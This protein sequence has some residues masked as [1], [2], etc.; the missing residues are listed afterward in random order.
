MKYVDKYN[1]SLP[2]AVFLCHDTYDHNPNP[3]AISATT[4]NKPMREVV[5]ARQNCDMEKVV[6]ISQLISSRM[7]TA[8]H[9]GAEAAWRNPAAIKNALEAKGM[10]RIADR[11]II[12]PSHLELSLDSNLL[13]VYLEQRVSKEVEGY[14]VTGKFDIVY[15][16][17]LSDYKSTTVWSYVFGSNVQD[18]IRQG[19]IYRYLAPDKITS[20]VIEI[21]Y[22]FTDWSKQRAMQDKEY[23]QAKYLT[24]QFPLWSLDKTEM[25]L[26]GRLQMLKNLLPKEQSVLPMC[27]KEELWQGDTVWKYYKDPSKMTR[28]SKN[29]DSKDN[30][31]AERDAQAHMMDQGKGKIVEF[32]GLCRRCKYCS[33]VEICDQAAMLKEQGLLALDD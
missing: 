29:F 21:Q 26:I 22:L 16:G 12:N 31:N 3:N 32:P 13:P 24:K 9:D 8:I 18:Y 20:D 15:G 14:L 10:S 11:I 27:T 1:I 28:A 23:P 5:L 30:P 17:Q 33:V 2:L 25:Y 7:G 4:F 19:S 6:D